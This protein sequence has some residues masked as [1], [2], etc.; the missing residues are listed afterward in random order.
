[1]KEGFLKYGDYNLHHV[2]WGEKGHKVLLIHSMGMDGHSMDALAENLKEEYQVLS[3][4]ILNHGDSDP[5]KGSISLP[6]HAEV[7]R[8]CYTQ[9][10][11]SPSVLIGHSVGGMMGMILAAK[12]PD[13]FE[14]LVL[15]DISP[16]DFT[17]Y[18][19]RPQPPDSFKDEAEALDWLKERY[20]SF[21]PYY[22]ENR[23]KYAFRKED[24]V[25]RLKPRGDKIRGGLATDL[26]PYVE[27][28][29]APTLLL[30][31]EESDLVTPET[32]ERMENTVPDIE[33][34]KVKG[35]GHMIPQNR[36]KEFEKLVKA[37]LERVF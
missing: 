19:P 9:L 29:K 34:I 32:Q 14:G 27:R 5:P 12:Y 1:M 6:D 7:M 10:G 11:F 28:I 15:V 8:G 20:P 35:T 37:Y 16:F 31:G 33:A 24:G 2:R 22:Y 26:W 36:P 25:L 18:S 30:I 13:E 21:T 4:T 3:L 23:L 17:R